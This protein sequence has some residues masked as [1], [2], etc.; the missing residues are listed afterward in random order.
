MPS[1]RH[2]WLGAERLEVLHFFPEGTWSDVTL[3]DKDDALSNYQTGF[4]P[5]MKWSDCCG[6]TG[7]AIGKNPDHI[8]GFIWFLMVRETFLLLTEVHSFEETIR[9]SAKYLLCTF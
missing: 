2:V 5:K 1:Q 4:N 6:L 9:V 3:R 7:G 8:C